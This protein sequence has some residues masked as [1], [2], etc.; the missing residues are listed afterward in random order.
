MKGDAV[1]GRVP[2]LGLLLALGVVAGLVPL[3]APPMLAL[4][5]A[6]GAVVMA[7]LL[8]DPRLG[9][10]LMAVSIPLETAGTLG[11]V[12]GNLP[13]TLAKLLTVATLLAWLV[14][15]AMRRVRFRS[16][17]WMYL[18]L[19][20]FAAACLSVAGASE[21][22]NGLEALLRL[23]TTVMFFFLVAQLADSP[24]VLVACLALFVLAAAAAASYS[25]IQRYLPGSSFA[26]RLGWEEA[27]ARRSGVELDIVEQRMVGLVK[28]S[29][30]L[31]THAILLALNA[32]LLLAPVAALSGMRGTRHVLAR[33]F[34]LG[35]A[36]VLTASVVVSYARTGLILV[37]FALLLMTWRGLVTISHAKLV[38]GVLVVALA[39]L[40]LPDKYA[41]RVLDPAAYTTRSASISTRMN[42]VD[43]GARQFLDH[44]LLGVGYG[45]R[46]GIFEYYTTYPDKKHAATPHNAY[47]QVAS[48]TGAIGLAILLAFFW[49]VHRHTRA[50]V[51]RFEAAQRPDLARIGLALDTSVLVFLLAGLALDLFDK[52][53]PH[54]WFLVGMCA[55]YSLVARDLDAPKYVSPGL[56]AVPPPAA[57]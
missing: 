44:P 36:A 49:K 9:L 18:L 1:T 20:Y 30:G 5:V 16:L 38:A 4:G 24:R 35:I 25:L 54:A 41:A 50:A 43:A 47:V 52:G 2:P 7:L 32:S 26:F 42:L 48:Q 29:T 3:L 12:T 11:A 15:L 19:A 57:T 34:W 22:S 46:Y 21:A 55:A 23:S 17:P 37:L 28:R 39:F 56:R 51:R 53:M 14:H 40:L 31:S 45:N 27:S 13:L 10:F 8:R 33:L 6:G